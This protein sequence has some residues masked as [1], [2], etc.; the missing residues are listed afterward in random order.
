MII[1]KRQMM[2]NPSPRNRHVRFVSRDDFLRDRA[3]VPRARLHLTETKKWL[4]DR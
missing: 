3:R 4:K 2:S 1:T